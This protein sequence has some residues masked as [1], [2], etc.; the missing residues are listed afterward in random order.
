MISTIASIFRGFHLHMQC[1]LSDEE[2]WIKKAFCQLAPTFCTTALT[3]G[4]HRILHSWTWSLHRRCGKSTQGLWSHRVCGHRKLMCGQLIISYWVP[5]GH[6]VL[7]EPELL[8]H[9]TQ[10]LYTM[11]NVERKTYLFTANKMKRV[12]VLF[13]VNYI[14]SGYTLHMCWSSMKITAFTS[15]SLTLRTSSQ[16]VSYLSSTLTA[17]L[18]L[19]ELDLTPL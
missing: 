8:Y 16:I 5:E 7:I 2:Y 6:T 3:S 9:C 10:R 15:M 11:T 18:D 14:H 1:F 13:G 17:G 19:W 12:H 4:K